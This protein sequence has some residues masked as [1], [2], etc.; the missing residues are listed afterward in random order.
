[1]QK[2]LP[3]DK[4]GKLKLVATNLVEDVE[5]AKLGDNYKEKKKS[6]ISKIVTKVKEWWHGYKKLSPAKLEAA[7]VNK[8]L[9][10]AAQKAANNILH[11]ASEHVP[12]YKV[13]SSTEKGL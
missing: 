9:I 3:G 13:S 6:I 7:D 12:I 4:E 10:I 8:G 11:S 5:K 1:M 2:L